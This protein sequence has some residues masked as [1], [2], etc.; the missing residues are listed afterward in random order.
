MNDKTRLK[1]TSCI[2][3][4]FGFHNEKREM[5]FRRLAKTY[6]KQYDYCMRGG[7]WVDNPDYRPDAPEYDG[8]W[9]NYNSKQIWAPSKDG[10]G[11]KVVFD[12]A[13]KV[14]GKDF[15]RHE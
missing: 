2:F 3:C 7:Q 14:Y 11:M 8:E 10:L 1:H 6:P 4:G 15:Y 12:M 5:R 9:K 13:N